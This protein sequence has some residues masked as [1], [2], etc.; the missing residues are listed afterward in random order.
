MT[1]DSPPWGPPSQSHTHSPPKLYLRLT[2]QDLL[3][4]RWLPDIPHAEHVS[5]VQQGHQGLPRQPVHGHHHAP[6]SLT[7]VQ[8]GHSPV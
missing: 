7:R 2:H 1:L 4:P 6:L 3:R 8:A 5:V